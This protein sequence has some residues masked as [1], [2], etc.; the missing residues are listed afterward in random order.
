MRV[1]GFSHDG[2]DFEVDDLGPA[3]G[4]AVIALHGFPSDRACWSGVAGRLIAG[5]YRVLAPD[6]R[7][8]RPGAAPAGRRAYTVDLLAAD[9]VALA[10]AAGVERFH[11]VGHD[12]GAAVAWHLS[13]T[14]P[15]RVRALTAVSVPHPA[16]FAASMLRS[17]QALRSWYMLAFQLPVVPEA[18]LGLAGG[19]WFARSLVSSGLPDDVAARYARRA[20]H[21]G[22]MTGPLNWYR[23]LPL[24]ARHP[25]GKVRVPTTMVWSA[26]DRFC[27]RAGVEATAAH[28]S[29]PYRLVEVRGGHWLPE[30]EPDAVAD[31]VMAAAARH[32]G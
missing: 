4:H 1:D 26:A 2:L 6:Q 27:G 24:G 11:L 8:Y 14:R 15:E 19:R 10:D 20:T 32:P 28:V 29:G 18:L 31:A 22:A 7:G 5:G 17:D 30:T 25:T 16:A 23:A 21:P 12:W 13:A 9:V 3:G